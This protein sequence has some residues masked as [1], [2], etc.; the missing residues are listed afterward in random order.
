MDITL[1]KLIWKIIYQF[2]DYRTK[3][4]RKP[5]LWLISKNISAHQLTLLSLISAA[6]ASYFFLINWWLLALFAAVHLILDSLDGVV[7]RLSQINGSGR[8]FDLLADALPILLILLKIGWQYQDSF[9]YLAAGLFL[10]SLIIYLTSKL[11][12]PFIHP[13]TIVVVS[14]VIATLPL[15]ETPLKPLMIGIY[16]TSSICSAYI[17]ARQLQWF[18]SR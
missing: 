10:A 6:A 5:A 4:L 16:L 9:S 12:A 17:L 3:R 1:E 15:W 11:K 8:Y 18:I 7:A 13:R 14:A 2:Q